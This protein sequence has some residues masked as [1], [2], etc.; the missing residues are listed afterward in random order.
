MKILILNSGSSS[1]KF[2]LLK[3]PSEE[4]ITS[5][6]IDRIGN[7]ASMIKLVKKD[8]EKYVQNTLINTHE[9]GVNT[10]IEL[11]LNKEFDFIQN[12]N[13]I[14]AVGHRI[15][16]GGEWFS[17]S[18]IIT[19]EILEKL[20][21]CNKLA[22]LHNP[23]NIDGI[24]ASKKLLPKAIQCGT[25]D[26][27]FH[28]SM[29]QKAYMYAIPYE[30]YEN[31]KIRRYGFHGSS[32]RFV[33]AEAAKLAGLDYNNCKIIVCHLGNGS[34]ITAIKNGK[35]V[36]TTMG[37]TPLEGLMMGTRCG[38]MDLGAA[39]Y[40]LNSKKITPKNLDTI[41]NKKS[42]FAGIT[43][44]TSD[45]REIKQAAKDGNERAILALDMFTYRVKKYI[46]SYAAAMGGVDIIAFTGGIGENN[47]DLRHTICNNMEFLGL[48]II[49]KDPKNATGS[50]IIFSKDSSR[51]KAM[52][53]ETDEEIVIARDTY[54][55]ISD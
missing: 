12:K 53:V 54:N 29:P 34:S 24:L 3:M 39:L 38:D 13:E 4:V 42:G 28:Q 17:E 35:S 43:G 26:T 49:D 44:F 33:S 52:V 18:T 11:L 5:G 27:A 47:Q 40:M 10:L 25:F 55:L 45:M 31:D 50:N 41:L 37:L 46:G 21:P 16:H 6:M 9:E 15:V 32:H 19:D 48:E 14:F 2:Q 30:Y 7:E 20:I 23:A 22:P 51:I 1:I 8:G 36:D